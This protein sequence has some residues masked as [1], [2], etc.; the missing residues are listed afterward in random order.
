MLPGKAVPSLF[1]S[2]WPALHF[3]SPRITGS[4]P[5]QS[6]LDSLVSAHQ[7]Y[8][9]TKNHS[10]FTG[11]NGFFI[12]GKNYFAL[13]AVISSSIVLAIFTPGNFTGAP[14]CATKLPCTSPTL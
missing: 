4:F 1:I 8:R 12:L 9:E 5:F 10:F 11:K 2:F 6:G 3:K 7:I 14:T 13:T